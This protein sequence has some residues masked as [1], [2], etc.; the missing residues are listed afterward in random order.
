MIHMIQELFGQTVRIDGAPLFDH[1]IGA[2]KQWQGN[3]E[4]ERLGGLE[5]DGQLDFRD[6]LHRQVSCFL[7]LE[8]AARA[9]ANSMR[10]SF[11]GWKPAKACGRRSR[12]WQGRP[13]PCAPRRRCRVPCIVPPV[14]ST[15]SR[16]LA[17]G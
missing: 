13:R 16:W 5:V 4:A 12:F 1:F 2:S 7:A 11:R 3:L 10:P 9:N 15:T 17:P 6:L 14:R 8:N